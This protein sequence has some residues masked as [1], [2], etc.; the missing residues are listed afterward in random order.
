MPIA[1]LTDDAPVY[2]RPVAEPAGL[3]APPARPR[4]AGRQ[5]P[6]RARS[7][8]CSRTP[9]L[10]EQGVDLAPVRPLGA[11]Q[12]GGR[13]RRRRRGPACSRGRRTASRS[14]LR[15]QP[16][17]LRARPRTRRGSRRWPR[18]RATSPAS[19]PSRSASPTASTSAT[20]R[21][22]RSCGSSA[23]A[24]RGMAEACRA[25]DVPVVSGNVSLYNETDGRSI[26]RRRRSRWSA[27]IDDLGDSP[28]R[29]LPPRRRPPRAA[30]RRPL[31]SSA[32]RPTCACSTASSA[33]RPPAVDLDA[34]A[35]LGAPAARRRSR[36]AWC[37]PR[38]TSRGGRPRGDAGRG[39]LR[40]GIGAR[41][42]VRSRRTAL[43]SESQARAVVAV[44][45]APARARSSPLAEELG[46]PAR[47]AG[48]TGGDRL[49]DRGRRRARSTRRSRDLQ[50]SSGRPRCPTA[51]G[52]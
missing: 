21:T 50:R 41:L 7:S 43:F 30:R 40:P 19:A 34:E 24:M 42:R 10:G 14:T 12:H 52:L 32:A 16:G 46:V 39:D 44:R 37:A 36:R 1:P 49:R 26:L 31:P 13:A 15:R 18:R 22:P 17:L 25:L 35:R 48:E 20:P 33:A 51:L 45:A 4:G 5:R 47:E 28:G 29:A 23:S 27:S 38:T 11:H 9:E 2:Q 6:D 8:A 3:A